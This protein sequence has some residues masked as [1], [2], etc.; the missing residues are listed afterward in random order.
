MEGK[1]T[2]LRSE[3][4]LGSE[5][6]SRRKTL[7]RA[8][9]GSGKK[10]GERIGTLKQRESQSRGILFWFEEGRKC[11]KTSKGAARIAQ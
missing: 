8:L 11:E 4:L 5:E 3:R 9:W 2:I 7:I 6:T 10:E 1:E